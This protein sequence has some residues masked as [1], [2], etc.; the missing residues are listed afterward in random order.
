MQS[1]CVGASQNDSSGKHAVNEEY[2]EKCPINIGDSG[3]HETAGDELKDLFLDSMGYIA[4]E[5]VID[6]AI[7]ADYIDKHNES[8]GRK[9]HSIIS[10]KSIAAA[11]IVIVMTVIGVFPAFFDRDAVGNDKQHYNDGTLHYYTSR[12]SAIELLGDDYLFSHMP[13]WNFVEVCLTTTD[14]GKPEDRASWRSL[15][16]LW[17]NTESMLFLEL[18]FP[19]G[20]TYSEQRSVLGAYGSEIYNTDIKCVSVEYCLFGAA[21]PYN[22]S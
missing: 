11:V 2:N 6:Y 10:Y 12:E 14:E 20:C 17:K 16:Y 21:A 4:D 3:G 5:L 19:A 13:E 18:Y 7:R 1:C 22:S 15:N 9:R 8:D